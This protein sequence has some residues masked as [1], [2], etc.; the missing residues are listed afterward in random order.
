MKSS[1][2]P[3]KYIPSQIEPKWQKRWA[4]EEIYQFRLEKNKENYYNLVE[5]PY[6]SGDLHLG[7]W[8]T[9][10][11]ADAHA[12]YMRMTGK[13]VFYPNGFDA[14][15]L[16]AENAAIKRNIHPQDLTMKNIETMKKQFATMGTMIDWSH[17]AITCLPDYYKWNQWI[18]IKMFEKGLAY[19]GKALSNWCPS[20]QTVLANEGIEDGKC[21][22]CGS[23]VE[24]K[25]IEQWFLKITA[26]ADEL[27]WDNTDEKKKANGVDWPKSVREGQNN[28]IGRSE[29]AEIVFSVILNG[30]EGSNK[31]SSSSTQNDNET[32]DVFTTRPDTLYGA[33][34]LVV[35]PEHDIVAELLNGKWQMANGKLNEV[36]EYV[37]GAKKKTEMERKEQKE[38]TGVF[39]GLYALH[40][41]TKK[42]IPIWVADYVLWGYGTGAIMAVPAH[43][44]RDFEF[45]KKY[46]LGIKVV[47]ANEMKQSHKIAASSAEDGSPRN[48]SSSDV[49][50]GDGVI[51]N[52]ED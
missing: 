18:F 35:A 16:P 13:N 11:N 43:D 17:E 46:N 5:L 22:R 47:I 33:T 30:S 29:G 7:H 34:F 14:F 48:D 4:E 39:S 19:R 50:V 2:T 28:W 23:I 27:L 42:E 37:E 25:E 45:A 1:K 38:K 15:G 6:P 3:G 49:Y 40:P 51:I 36:R 9:F 8:F 10:V 41:I 26:L 24:Q 21:W 12:R 44:E 31:D 32:I 52:S 20:C